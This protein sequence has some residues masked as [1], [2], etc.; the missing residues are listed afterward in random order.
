M[1]E[2]DTKDARDEVRPD[3]RAPETYKALL[4]LDRAGWAETWLRRNPDYIDRT[5]GC[6]PVPSL[7]L[8]GTRVL[9]I[10]ATDFDEAPDWGLRFCRIAGSALG[11]CQ[12]LLAGRLERVGAG[13]RGPTGVTKR[14]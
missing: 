14:S 4:N 6:A 9:V 10:P 7:I 13:G 3:W 8:P 5:V 12:D 2:D 11:G 1:K